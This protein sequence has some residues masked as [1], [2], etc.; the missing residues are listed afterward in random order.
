MDWLAEANLSPEMLRILFTAFVRP[1]LEYAQAVWSPRLIKHID[2]IE[3]VQR[4]ATRLVSGYRNK[5]YEDRLRIINLPSLK[6]RRKISDMVEVYKHLHVY[7]KSSTSQK[8]IIR[9]RPQ[10]QHNHELQ[11]NFADDSIRGYQTN[12]LY[13]RSVDPWNSLGADVVAT[14]T[15]T[16]FKEQLVNEWKK[17]LHKL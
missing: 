4:R 11:R 7:D 16:N 6:I 15:I 14:T 1:H 12:S 13:Y 17:D 2:A 3:S 8:F 10:R 5:S 9:K